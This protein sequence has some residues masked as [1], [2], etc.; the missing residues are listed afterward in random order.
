[1]KLQEKK[2]DIEKAEYMIST[3]FKRVIMNTPR[4]NEVRDL[5]DGFIS[6]NPSTDIGKETA[7]VKNNKFF[8]LIGDFR[9]E[10]KD[11]KN[12]AD[13][14]KVYKKLIKDGAEV[15]LWSNY[16]YI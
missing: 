5:T 9:E 16:E 13:C 6:Y 11:C 14:V 15:S 10:L 1:M 3:V 8:I 12:T 4:K 2:P 7:I